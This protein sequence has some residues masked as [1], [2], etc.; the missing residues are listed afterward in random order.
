MDEDDT[1]NVEILQT[2]TRSAKKSTSARPISN[3]RD[4]SDDE[5]NRKAAMHTNNNISPLEGANISNADPVI[6]GNLNPVVVPSLEGANILNADSVI[7]ANLNPVVV[8]ERIPMKH[9][10]GGGQ[11]INKESANYWNLM[12]EHEKERMAFER[13]LHR[14]NVELMDLKV[15]IEKERLEAMLPRLFE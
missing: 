2:T 14:K 3:T 12:T 13:E 11:M 8:L 9:Q 4:D 6:K 1:N 10:F 5:P 7:K 15:R